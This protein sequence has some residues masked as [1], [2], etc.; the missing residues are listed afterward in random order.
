MWHHGR[1]APRH[2]AM[3]GLLFSE[4]EFM[5]VQFNE[6][7][8]EWGYIKVERTASNDGRDKRKKF[9][10]LTIKHPKGHKIQI[11]ATKEE[12]EVKTHAEDHRFPRV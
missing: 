2:E 8:F 4:G 9:N 6:F 11:I 5:K 12:L 10:I 1:L 3:R 7:G